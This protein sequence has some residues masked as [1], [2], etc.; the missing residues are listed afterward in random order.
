MAVE[1]YDGFVV[2]RLRG[3]PYELGLQHGVA[4]RG[5]IWS[6]WRACER[7][8]LNA[9][10]RRYGW[11][12]RHALIA[13]ARLMERYVPP[14]LRREIRGVADGSGLAYGN[15]LL[16]NC[17]DDLMNNL[18]I[19]DRLAGRFACSAF[20]V[21]GS[22]AAD[23][24]VVAGRNLDYW[25]RSDFAAAGY[26][27]TAQLQ[28]HVVVLVYEP[29][30]GQPFVSVGW[31][32]LVNVVTAQNAA[33]LA[34][35]CLTSPAWSERPWGTPMPFLYRHV[36]QHLTSLD[37]AE[38]YL[39]AARR[40]IGNN[41]LVAA[42]AE[43]DAR[44]FELTARQIAVRASRGGVV[45]ATNQFQVPALAAEQKGLVTHSS[46]QRLGRLDA[47]LA[48]GRLD[49]AEAMAVV[50]DQECL[51]PAHAECLWSRV[52]NAGTI[53]STVFEP[54]AGRLWVRAGDRDSRQWQAI[55][56]PGARP[57]AAVGAA[58]RVEALA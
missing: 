33:G 34:L 31:P 11:G 24:T 3:E 23:G 22:R 35:A 26:E 54:G 36:A 28:R 2:A 55:A 17:F 53:Y 9:R 14:P 52:L 47:L 21:V 46:P 45:A 37:A 25:F 32:G 5:E 58:E 29:A 43:R 27:P 1:R 4:L 7:L 39:R 18:R 10:G 41:L 38:A 12:L 42:G 49:V 40:T 48:D 44:V 56:V 20:A 19:F 13:V 16:L 50:G 51:D 30:Q 6:L 15:V 57:L 8:I